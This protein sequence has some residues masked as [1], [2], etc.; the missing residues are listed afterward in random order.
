MPRESP[1]RVRNRSGRTTLSAR[2]ASTCGCRRGATTRRSSA[3]PS[4]RAVRGEVELAEGGERIVTA[5]LQRIANL[6]RQGWYSGDLHVHRPL[7][8]I[9]L[10]LAA[11][12][13]NVAPIITWWNEQNY[14]QNRQI[15]GNLV[16][17]P[18]RDR[19]IEL[20]AGED[21]RAG[22]ALLF[23]GLDRPLPLA[24][25]TS[26]VSPRRLALGRGGPPPQRRGWI[27]IEKPFWWDV[28]IWL[29]AGR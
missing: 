4:G 13:L 10:H 11:E 14:W 24:E 29:A 7:D 3:A 15:P 19:L 9:P 25:S 21:E 1:R 12:E 26:G 23:F 20:M 6:A 8:E 18:E 5:R 22:G 16:L 27:D 28:P 2:A 17:S